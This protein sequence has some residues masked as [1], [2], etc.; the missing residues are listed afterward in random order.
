MNNTVGI[1]ELIKNEGMYKNKMY[2]MLG[3]ELTEI[4]LGEMY[5][6]N[7]RLYITK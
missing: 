3:R 4:P 6:R 7:K 2:D 5:I 1:E